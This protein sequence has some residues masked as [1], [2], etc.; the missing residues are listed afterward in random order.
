[1]AYFAQKLSKFVLNI[2]I[3]VRTREALE[4]TWNLKIPHSKPG[5]RMKKMKKHLEFEIFQMNFCFASS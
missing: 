4:P 5:I 2:H 3:A 1:M